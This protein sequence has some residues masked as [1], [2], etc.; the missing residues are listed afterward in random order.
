MVRKTIYNQNA[1][2][3][4]RGYYLQAVEGSKARSIIGYG[5]FGSF[6]IMFGQSDDLLVQI[7]KVVL[8]VAFRF[9]HTVSA[10]R[11]ISLQLSPCMVL[12]SSN[13]EVDGPT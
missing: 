12:E 8:L 9:R 13:N 7:A 10:L 2:K 3:G 5:S 4:R 1:S 11:M 6:R